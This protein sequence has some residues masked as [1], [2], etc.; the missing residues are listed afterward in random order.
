MN[1]HVY[2]DNNATTPL[3]PDVLAAFSD[4]L[5]RF[6]NPS[7]MHGFG[8]EAANLLSDARAEAAAILGAEPGEITFTSGGTESNNTVLA[9]FAPGIPVT[10]GVTPPPSGKN[11]IIVSAIEHPA[12]LET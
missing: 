1:R 7:S 10:D 9:S 11:E 6:G 2:L 8:R 3:D 4:A 12:I 5:A